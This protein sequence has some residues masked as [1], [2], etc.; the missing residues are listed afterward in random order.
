MRLHPS[1][2]RGQHSWRS[3]GGNCACGATGN[4]VRLGGG[5]QLEVQGSKAD[6]RRPALNSPCCALRPRLNRLPRR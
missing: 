5:F 1:V 4:G 6:A 2:S 3:R